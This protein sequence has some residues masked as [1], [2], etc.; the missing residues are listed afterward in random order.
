VQS[1]VQLLRVAAPVWGTQKDVGGKPKKSK[2][3]TALLTTPLAAA[4][5]KPLFCMR[6]T[7]SLSL[8]PLPPR[9]L[10]IS[11]SPLKPQ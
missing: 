7:L 9:S 11:C 1:A 5:K 10:S 6:V 2:P 4:L 8:L 3:W